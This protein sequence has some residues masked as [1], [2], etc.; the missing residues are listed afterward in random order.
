MHLCQWHERIF[1]LIQIIIKII[2]II[3]PTFSLWNFHPNT[4]FS[5]WLPKCC[6][7]I[8][9]LDAVTFTISLWDIKSIDQLKYPFTIHLMVTGWIRDSHFQLKIV[10]I[11]IK[12]MLKLCRITNG[13]GICSWRGFIMQPLIK[14]IILQHAT[15]LAK[16]VPLLGLS[17]SPALLLYLGQGVRKWLELKI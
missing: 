1:V 15:Y 3:V 10:K 16:L 7:I 13:A 11:C 4:Y 2:I 17:S 8:C 6:W 5:T 14:P 9:N 12:Q